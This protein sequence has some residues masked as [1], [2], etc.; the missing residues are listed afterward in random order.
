MNE[1]DLPEV[2][3]GS[4]AGQATTAAR[5][6]AAAFGGYLV[7]QGLISGDTAELITALVTT[8]TPML[9]GMAITRM[10]RKKLVKAVTVAKTKTGSDV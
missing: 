3:G 6:L 8:A 9:I 5:Y 1:T 4:L 2:H 10:N 7:G